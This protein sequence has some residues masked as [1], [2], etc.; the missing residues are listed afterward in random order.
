MAENLDI[1]RC[2]F[3]ASKPFFHYDIPKKQIER[4]MNDPRVTV[5]SS[6]DIVAMIKTE[7]G[8]NN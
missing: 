2:W 7:L 6:R 8:V 1:K 5:V 3:H 4:I